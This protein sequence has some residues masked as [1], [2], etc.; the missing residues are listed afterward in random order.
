M[1]LDMYLTRRQKGCDEYCDEEIGYWHEATAIHIWFVQN[2][3]NGIDEH[4]QSLVSREQLENLLEVCQ[5]VL[6][7]AKCLD[8]QVI[9]K[10]K[11]FGDNL[12][13]K[14]VI[15]ILKKCDDEIILLNADYSI[16]ECENGK[17]VTKYGTFGDNLTKEDILEIFEELDD[18]IILLNG[19]YLIEEYE[20]GFYVPNWFEIV[21]ILPG[22]SVNE[23]DYQEYYIEYV[24]KTVNILKSALKETNF[25][26]EEIY[27]KHHGKASHMSYNYKIIDF[28]STRNVVEIK[29]EEEFQEFYEILKRLG[30][31]D[32]LGRYQKFSHWR[33]LAVTNDR[34][35]HQFY[36]EYDN[37]RGLTWYDNKD[38]P[39]E[40]YGIE[41]LKVT[42]LVDDNEK[43]KH[44]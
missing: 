34:D 3:L 21:H 41:P 30:I 2:V 7:T 23:N 11:T 39:L 19:E 10:V 25:D 24:K 27:Y 15:E 1:E 28:L 22:I 18:E 20:K 8:G 42:D 5:K 32:I 9:G 40:R 12:S 26:K 29:K 31:E 37:S 6:D 36:F 14:E 13:K 38:E 16:E 44:E 43:L 4:Q 33:I 17:V 35:Y